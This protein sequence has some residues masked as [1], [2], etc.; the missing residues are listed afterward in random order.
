[1]FKSNIDLND[2]EQLISC[3]V[4]PN[5]FIRNGTLKPHEKVLFEILCSYDFL[6]ADGERKGWCDVGLDRVAEEMGL[7]KRQVQVYL[8]RLVEKGFVTIIYRNNTLETDCRSSIYVLNILPGLS[9][10]DRKRIASTRTIGIKNKIS[11][12]N[13]IKVQTSKGMMYTSQ[14][15]FDLE[16]L[17]TGKRSSCVIKGEI[18]EVEIDKENTVEEF[19]GLKITTGRKVV[20]PE[21]LKR[22]NS[23]DPG[24]Y[25]DDPI[26]RILS[27]NYKDLKPMDICKYFGFVY[28]QVYPNDPPYVVSKK[29][30]IPHIKRRLSQVDTDILIEMI[31]FFITNYDRLFKNENYL[32]PRI[33]A[34]GTD[35]IW[36]KL[37]EHYARATETLE[38]E[39]QRESIQVQMK[40]AITWD[41]L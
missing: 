27:G 38:E 19:D 11:G 41:D 34:I 24:Y 25:S 31:K 40:D 3:C 7:S 33:W 23:V 20:D 6:N 17:V 39:K 12:L 22:N 29:I 32:R 36:Q 26:V 1:M 13:I 14:E 37:S 21:S 5:S 18:G 28:K 30:E 8:K 10:A 2:Y 9:E 35:W 16:Y 4:F 15:E